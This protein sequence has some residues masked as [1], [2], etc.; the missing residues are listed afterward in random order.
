[1]DD[2]GSRYY[3]IRPSRV[4]G[5]V[6]SATLRRL[7]ESGQ[8][9][10]D[11]LVAHNGTSKW[12]IASEIHGLRFDQAH[13]PKPHE[14]PTPTAVEQPLMPVVTGDP[15]G[16]APIEI[17]TWRP[18][19]RG[20]AGQPGFWIAIALGAVTAYGAYCTPPMQHAM[21][22]LRREFMRAK[23]RS[24]LEDAQ[25]QSTPQEKITI[26]VAPEFFDLVPP[27]LREFAHPAD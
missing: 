14:P 10:P 18:K 5:P 12:R 1:M 8:I 13:A 24:A 3:Y 21:T 7:A 22:G 2:Q 11:D 20:R 4:Y 6:S 23:I 26:G 27:E 15:L 25:R 17:T 19:R 9:G 16:E